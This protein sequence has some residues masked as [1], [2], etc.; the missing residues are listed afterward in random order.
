[1]MGR[2]T[3]TSSPVDILGIQL[4]ES[5]DLQFLRERWGLMVSSN[6]VQ[7]N[8]ESGAAEH[9]AIDVCQLA[10]IDPQLRS[11][12]DGIHP[13]VHEWR[14]RHWPGNRY[15]VFQVCDQAGIAARKHDLL[16]RNRN[17]VAAPERIGRVLGNNGAVRV[18]Q[19]NAALGWEETRPETQNR[20]SK[21]RMSFSPPR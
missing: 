16:H 2:N 5:H 13:H 20:I 18:A 21:P 6:A 8:V 14:Q 15:P 19:D 3:C 11:P 9:G 10:G 4:V 1:M 12:D 7:G 17:R